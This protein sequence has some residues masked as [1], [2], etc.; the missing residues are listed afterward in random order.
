MCQ[1]DTNECPGGLLTSNYKEQIKSNFTGR[2]LFGLKQRVKTRQHQLT[3]VTGTILKVSVFV[4]A[5][6][7]AFV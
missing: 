7:I 5:Y 6:I 2:S 3:S 4:L 1:E